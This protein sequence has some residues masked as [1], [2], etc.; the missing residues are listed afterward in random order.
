M[1]N[2]AE[3]GYL[4]IVKF[5]HFNRPEGCTMSAITGAAINGYIDVVKFLCENRNE[6]FT[7]NAI[8]FCGNEIV[9]S[10]L[11]TQTHLLR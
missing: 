4:D 11:R 6:G 3:K 8:R 9:L 7:Y 2:A 1:D 10:Y 5:L